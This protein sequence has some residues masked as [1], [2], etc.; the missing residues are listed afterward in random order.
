M[1][2]WSIRNPVEL[3]IIYQN[4][5]F[6]TD[7]KYIDFDYKS[8]YDWMARELEKKV[9]KPNEQC[10]YPIWAW[11]CWDSNRN[12][13]PDLRTRLGKRNEELVLVEFDIPDN[14][15]LLSEF[16][17]W[18]FVLNNW[19]LPI[20]E[21]DKL[22]FENTLKNSPPDHCNKLITQSW[23]NIFYWEKLDP[24]YHGTDLGSSIQAVFWELKK[25]WIT[26]TTYFKSK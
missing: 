10:R 8:A 14:L 19:Y 9:K 15:V 3:D 13:R 22:N 24:T 6:F 7:E 21:K 17:L 4:G 25:E 12:C 5:V 20:N 18:H 23:Q 11:K 1:R 16:H 2:L 26:K